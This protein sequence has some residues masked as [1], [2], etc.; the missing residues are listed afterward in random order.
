MVPPEEQR[1]IGEGLTEEELS[2]FDIL[3]RP[4]MDLSEEETESVK[5]VTRDLLNTLKAERRVLE[6]TI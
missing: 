5:K 4:E 6:E 1:H 2:I 3:T